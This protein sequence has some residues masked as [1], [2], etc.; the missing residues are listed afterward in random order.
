MLDD[1]HYMRRTPFR[2]RQS[3]TVLLWILNVAAF[4][5]Q[6]IFSGSLR[7]P[8]NDSVD[9]YFALSLGGLRHGFVWQLLTYQLMH[10]G[11][12][13]LL[14]NCW[15]IFMFGREVEE[16]LGRKSFLTLSFS[17]GVLGGLVQML[18]GRL[19]GVEILDVTHKGVHLLDLV[20]RF[21]LLIVEVGGCNG[22]SPGGIGADEMMA[23]VKLRVA[24]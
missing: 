1:R 8:T 5:V 13:H 4:V 6:L 2:A 15:A 10:G 20:E 24:A 3:A 19:L 23:L 16:A 18:A 14:L 21:Q 12:L 11:W 7:S 17:G 22:E 9:K